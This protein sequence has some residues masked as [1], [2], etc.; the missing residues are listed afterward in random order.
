MVLRTVRGNCC[1]LWLRRLQ[2]K[3]AVDLDLVRD[4]L[5][6]V[7][8]KTPEPAHV[9]IWIRAD[10]RDTRAHAASRPKRPEA[11]DVGRNAVEFRHS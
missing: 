4:D 7:A 5:A 3:D 1:T 10:E 6:A 2:L 9:S 8:Q 11:T